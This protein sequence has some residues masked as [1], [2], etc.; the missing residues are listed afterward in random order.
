MVI[1]AINVVI[2]ILAMIVVTAILVVIFIV[3]TVCFAYCYYACCLYE[4]LSVLG[5]SWSP[6]RWTQGASC[7]VLKSII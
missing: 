4:L 1:L 6:Q 3:N 2:V 7:S 5:F